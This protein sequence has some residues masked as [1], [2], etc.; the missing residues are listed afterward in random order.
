MTCCRDLNLSLA[1]TI[2]MTVLD[3][4]Q[5]APSASSQT[6]YQCKRGHRNGSRR[7]DIDVNGAAKCVATQLQEKYQADTL[8]TSAV[9]VKNETI[10]IDPQLLFQRLIAAGTRNDQLEEI[11]QFELCSYSPS[12]LKP[13]MLWGL[14]T[15][16]HLQMLSGPLMPKDVVGPTGQS[17]H[18]LDGGS[19][20]HRIPWQRGTTYNDICRRYTNYVTRT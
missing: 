15:N 6:R 14:L 19:L 11:F 13:D 12:I 3:G 18:V 4:L 7:E 10:Q 20:V 1:R 16:L 8:S 17:Q 2:L 9:K 5:Y